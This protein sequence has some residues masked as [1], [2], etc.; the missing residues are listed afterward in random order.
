MHKIEKNEFED[1]TERKEEKEEE[2]FL[3]PLIHSHVG[4]RGRS[5][6]LCAQM[7]VGRGGRRNGRR[8]R[9]IKIE[10]ERERH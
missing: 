1:E 7:C 10:R 2:A 9:A 6:P 8:E 3:L 5:S 4:R